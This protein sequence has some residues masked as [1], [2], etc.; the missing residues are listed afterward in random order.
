TERRSRVAEAVPA[1]RRRP[2]P[3]RGQNCRRTEPRTGRDGRYRRLLQTCPSAVQQGYEAE[4]H[5]ECH[6]RPGSMR[7]MSKPQTIDLNRIKAID[8]HVHAEVSCHDPEDPVMGEFFDAASAYFGAE[9]RRPTMDE[10]IAF[11]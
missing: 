2:A 4:C 5:V 10:T 9:R 6:H 1:H 3:Q 11:Y 7:P 8:V